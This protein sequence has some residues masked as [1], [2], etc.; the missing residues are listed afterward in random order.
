MCLKEVEV[1]PGNPT[2]VEIEQIPMIIL[3]PL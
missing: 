1:T 2:Q 3:V